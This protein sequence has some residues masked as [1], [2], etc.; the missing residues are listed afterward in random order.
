MH[1]RGGVRHLRVSG[2]GEKTRYVPLHGI[3]RDLI[4]DFRPIII[5]VEVLRFAGASVSLPL[6][7]TD[8]R[9]TLG[10]VRSQA[11][12]PSVPHKNAR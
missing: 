7:R 9:H 4:E 12:R 10:A 6:N 3:A 2:K 11:L 5:M 8:A 1:E